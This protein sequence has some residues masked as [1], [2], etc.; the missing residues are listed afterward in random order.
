MIQNILSTK[1]ANQTKK[2]P[3]HRKID[4]D[5]YRSSLKVLSYNSC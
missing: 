5:V 1:A 3:N 4:R 2:V